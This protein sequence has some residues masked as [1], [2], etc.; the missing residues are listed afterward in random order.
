MLF[1]LRI[2]KMKGNNWL[3]VGLIGVFFALQIYAYLK[4]SFNKT[5]QVT[6][7]QQD[8][9]FTTVKSVDTVYRY[10]DSEIS[11]PE[12]V[13]VIVIDSSCH[14]SDIR[15]YSDTI[16]DNVILAVISDTISDNRIQGR[17]FKYSILTSEVKTITKVVERN[18]NGIYIAPLVGVANNGRVG[19]GISV[20]HDRMA[21]HADLVNG[22]YYF[23]YRFKL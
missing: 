20:S 14:C 1:N 21:V 15:H 23:S 12:V 22:C 17:G 4:L 13:E 3:F 11:E 8:T 19:A 6:V 18:D 16:S 9:V 2:A 7:I 5:E 10:I